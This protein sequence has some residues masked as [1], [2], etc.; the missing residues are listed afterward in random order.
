MSYGAPI[1]IDGPQVAQYWKLVI[2]NY[3][4][5]HGTAAIR[6][7]AGWI[8]PPSRTT[9]PSTR[10]TTVQSLAPQKRQLKGIYDHMDTNRDGGV[11]FP[12]FA[13]YFTA[14]HPAAGKCI[15][16]EDT[17]TLRMED[18]NQMLGE[19]D[20]SESMIRPGAGRDPNWKNNHHNQIR[21]DT[22]RWC[23][24]NPED[25]VVS[26]EECMGLSFEDWYAKTKEGLSRNLPEDGINLK[27]KGYNG[28]DCD[29]RGP[30]KY[31][32]MEQN[33][34]ASIIIDNAFDFMQL[35]K[36]A[37]IDGGSSRWLLSRTRVKRPPLRS[38]NA[39]VSSARLLSSPTKT[40]GST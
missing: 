12:E 6:F 40:S 30:P 33:A 23:L 15:L 36:A 26:K 22:C 37:T 34:I 11:S 4:H 35:G 19:K 13:S 39:R 17:G 29:R 25:H 18:V 24:R 32:P 16:A 20:S 31:E 28:W 9:L 27:E 8:T 10:L 3:G 1:T 2:H 5:D 14:D 21:F 38:A 7:T